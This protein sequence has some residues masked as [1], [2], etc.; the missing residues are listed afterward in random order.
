MAPPPNNLRCL[1]SSVYGP[2]IDSSR[3]E[4][5]EE[6]TSPR[7]SLSGPCCVVG[8]FN[9]IRYTEEHLRSRKVSSAMRAF[10]DWI[11]NQELVDLPLLGAKFTWTN[12]RAN[13]IL[14]RLDRF[15]VS[16]KWLE[17][18]PFISQSART[19]SDHCSILLSVEGYA[20]HRLLSKLKTPQRKVKVVEVYSASQKEFRIGLYVFRIAKD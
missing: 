17:T 3:V 14:S 4:F 6:L 16:P 20:G 1:I 19:T 11:E 7:Q 15:L 13:P 2:S 8:D 12:G 18:F 10:S 5:W 9:I